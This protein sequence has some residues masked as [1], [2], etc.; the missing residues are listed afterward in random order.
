MSMVDFV[1]CL[2]A[3]YMWT[4]VLPSEFPPSFVPFAWCPLYTTYVLWHT[5]ALSPCL[6]FIFLFSVC[7]S[8]KIF[9]AWDQAAY[10]TA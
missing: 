4:C 7:S 2:G 8:N 6:I 1:D 9:R 5:L 3:K 10:D